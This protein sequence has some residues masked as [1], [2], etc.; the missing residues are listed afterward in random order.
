VLPEAKKTEESLKKLDEPTMKLTGTLLD[1]LVTKGMSKV[2]E[3][4]Q[5]QEASQSQR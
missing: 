2:V 1:T 5:E 4:L 3:Q